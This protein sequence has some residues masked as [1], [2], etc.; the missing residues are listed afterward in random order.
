VLRV[1]DHSEAPVESSYEIDNSVYHHPYTQCKR[2]F[3]EY[4][5]KFR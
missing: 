1:F 2:T 4:S 5:L 3:S